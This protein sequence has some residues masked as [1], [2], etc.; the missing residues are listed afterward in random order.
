MTESRRPSTKL[1]RELEKIMKDAI[2]RGMEEAQG[3]PTMSGSN[4]MMYGVP[5]YMPVYGIPVPPPIPAIPQPYYPTSEPD[6]LRKFL[7]EWSRL[8]ITK[9]P[10]ELVARLHSDDRAL[11]EALNAKLDVL[12]ERTAPEAEL[13]AEIRRRVNEALDGMQKK[14]P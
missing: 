13:V 12:L 6:G 8:R 11:L 2:R 3:R 1:S 9:A 5:E 14:T 7:E 10:T 4:V